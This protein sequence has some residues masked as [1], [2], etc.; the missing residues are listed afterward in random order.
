M[1]SSHFDQTRAI[2]TDVKYDIFDCIL[3]GFYNACIA[4]TPRIRVS[5]LSYKEKY[6]RM[7]TLERVNELGPE[8]FRV[9]L[10]DPTA[11]FTGYTVHMDINVDTGDFPFLNGCVYVRVKPVTAMQGEMLV[12]FRYQKPAVTLEYDDGPVAALKRV[13]A[14]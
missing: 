3:E 13:L 14:V 7:G 12:E 9:F 8:T 1:S 11:N 4:G 5:E 10:T 6:A 2:A